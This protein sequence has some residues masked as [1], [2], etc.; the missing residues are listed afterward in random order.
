MTSVVAVSRMGINCRRGD[1]Q[2]GEV[3]ANVRRAPYARQMPH[4]RRTNPAA[5]P[6]PD[7]DFRFPIPDSMT[8]LDTILAAPRQ[9][10]INALGDGD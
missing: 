5:V 4:G 8:G 7:S 9:T 2:V 3:R 6:V 1:G 10:G